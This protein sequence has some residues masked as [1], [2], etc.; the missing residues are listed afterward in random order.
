MIKYC[1][2]IIMVALLLVG[3]FEDSRD[4]I[5]FEKL[6]ISQ[7]EAV[8]EF[9]LL[10]REEMD[11]TTMRYTEVEIAEVGEEAARLFVADSFS[12]LN[13]HFS[14]G[15]VDVIDK[16]GNKYRA[17]YIGEYYEENFGAEKEYEKEVLELYRSREKEDDLPYIEFKEIDCSSIIEQVS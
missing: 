7:D 12:G 14:S 10:S 5:V 8:P 1:F 4:S 13:D 3:C 17:I 2:C 15:V 16:K 11:N 9:T 6:E